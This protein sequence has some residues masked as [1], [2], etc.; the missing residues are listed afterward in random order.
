[1][2]YTHPIYINLT[3][4]SLLFIQW[5]YLALTC[6]DLQSSSPT[7][8]SNH[9]TIA[10]SS[11]SNTPQRTK[12]S[13]YKRLG[14]LHYLYSSRNLTP[15]LPIP[16]FTSF[17]STSIYTL[18][19]QGD[20]IHPA[21]MLFLFYMNVSAIHLQFRLSSQPLTLPAPWVLLHVRWSIP[22]LK[23]FHPG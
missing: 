16:I 6:I 18:K 13:A 12:S 4:Q 7:P 22:L 17:I 20:M 19:S 11:S 15:L 9:T 10:L 21:L 5:H 23:W 1:M 3:L 14:N 8:L 2:L